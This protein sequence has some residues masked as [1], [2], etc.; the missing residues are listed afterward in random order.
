MD[1]GLT[2]VYNEKVTFLHRIPQAEVKLVVSGGGG[3][4]FKIINLDFSRQVFPL[5]SCDVT[6][7]H[8][9]LKILYP[10]CLARF[11][12]PSPMSVCN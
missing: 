6:V 2:S 7:K 12:L 9:L 11:S 3:V 4:D 1:T 10:S 5:T 8:K